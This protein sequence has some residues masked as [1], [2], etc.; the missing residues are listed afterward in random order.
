MY[1]QA[2]ST[3]YYQQVTHL[4]TNQV[5]RY[6]TSLIVRELKFQGDIIVRHITYETESYI[7]KKA[8]EQNIDEEESITNE[9][10][11]SKV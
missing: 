9:V 10:S 7:H 3:C 1:I 11:F 5:Q 8:K 2:Y 4:A 6:L